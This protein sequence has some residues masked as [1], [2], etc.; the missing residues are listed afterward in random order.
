MLRRREFLKLGLTGAALSCLSPG[1]EDRSRPAEPDQSAEVHELTDGATLYDDFDGRGNLQTYNKQNLAEPG[2]LSANLW[3]SS[4]GAEVISD[5]AASGL[6]TV[7]AED[8]ERVE[9]PLP[10]DGSRML[11]W[12]G[13]RDGHLETGSGVLE[14]KK[15]NIYGTAEVIAAGGG[16]GWVLR[17]A[18]SLT[19]LMGSMLTS[20]REVDFADF[21]TFSAD[22]MVPSA[23][24]AP[25]FYAALDYHTT[26]PEQPP[27][28]SWVSDVGLHKLS[29]GQLNLFAQCL[30]VNS[31]GGGN[32]FLLGQAR[33]DTWYNVRQD[34]VTRAEDPSLAENQLRIDYYL[35]GVLKDWIVPLDGEILLDPSRLGWGPNRLLV[36]FVQ[37][38]RGEGIAYFDNVNGVYRNRLK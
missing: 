15:G 19:H 31:G 7:V 4:Q 21:K 2:R 30:N 5:P 11:V 25:S 28:K 8:G 38:E 36:N 33:F 20:P 23:A 12:M 26:I 14:I 1:C 6:L 24:T 27:G 34:I 13:A 18:S 3:E 16:R 22:I 17:L 32:Y 9:G 35:N 37:E 29:N 10:S